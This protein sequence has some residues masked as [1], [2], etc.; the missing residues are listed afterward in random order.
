MDSFIRFAAGDGMPDWPLEIFLEISNV[1]NMKCAMCNT[2]S[3]LSTARKNVIQGLK[4]G[5][6]DVVAITPAMESLFMHAIQVHAFGFGE[7]TIHPQFRETIRHIRKFGVMVDFFTN[8]MNLDSDMCQFLVDSAI[9]RITLSMSGATKEDYENVYIGGDFE[10]VIEGL[11]LMQ[12]AKRL[13][14]TK[15]PMV[16]VN[17]IAFV[18]HVDRFMEFVKLMGECGVSVVHLKPLSTY[19]SIKELH[20]HIS[21]PTSE[22]EMRMLAQAKALASQYGMRISSEPYERQLGAEGT[23]KHRGR[24]SM[25]TEYV[26]LERFS[27]IGEA[28][29][30]EAMSNREPAQKNQTKYLDARGMDV[31][32]W[33]GKPCLE[34]FKTLYVAN[35]GDV[36][37][38][39]FKSGRTALGTIGEESGESIWNNAAYT[40]MRDGIVENSQYPSAICGGCLKAQIYP[41]GH[42]VAQK[43]STYNEWCLEVYGQN[44]SVKKKARLKKQRDNESVLMAHR[45]GS[46]DWY[47][48]LVGTFREYM[49]G[50]WRGATGKTREA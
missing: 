10:K 16:E 48:R 8:G 37:P 21:V 50:A 33:E 12:Q 38:C 29:Q 23:V 5:F 46:N 2:F 44:F 24:N 11:K 30:R 43:L 26:P 41:Q 39:C 25:S 28:R 7:P 17:S 22:I 27:G 15:Y 14:D 3:S 31:T 45:S 49:L 13:A 20:G 1:C 9:T 36:Y 35:N 6:M 34:P 18:H 4:R 32:A 40:A 42:A 47:A 19:D